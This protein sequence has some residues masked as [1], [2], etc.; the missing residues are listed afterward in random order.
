MFSVGGELKVLVPDTG[1]IVVSV[2]LQ[3]NESI[4]SELVSAEM[5]AR[6]VIQKVLPVRGEGAVAL[7]LQTAG[8]LGC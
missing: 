1:E 6:D 2:V 4:E 5:A 3:G 8:A 7:V